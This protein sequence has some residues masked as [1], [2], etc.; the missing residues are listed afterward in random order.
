VRQTYSS[1]GYPTNFDRGQRMH[2]CVGGFE[3]YDPHPIANGPKPM[4]MGCDMGRG[5]SGG[6]WFVDGR[7]ASVTSFGYAN[8]PDV[9]YGP[10]F[11]A[12]AARVYAEG[13]R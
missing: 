9:S 13:A 12:K 1:F 7:L 6:G 4:A 2:Y 10:Y 5:A 3:G 11:G 8:H